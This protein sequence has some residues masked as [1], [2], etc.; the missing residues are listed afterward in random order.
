MGAIS[1]QKDT[2]QQFNYVRAKYGN[3]HLNTIG[4]RN[5][6]GVIETESSRDTGV[7]A[8]QLNMAEAI[9][10]QTFSRNEND[11]SKTTEVSCKNDHV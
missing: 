5:L 9:T 6:T 7:N 3:S 11:T 1:S 10:S 8:S 4:G 2:P